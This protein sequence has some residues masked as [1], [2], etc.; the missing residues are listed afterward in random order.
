MPTWPASLDQTVLANLTR[1]RQSAKLRSSVDVGPAKQRK[2]YT[3]AVKQFQASM[4]MTGTQLAT[5]D[6]FYE[7][8]IGQGALS[9]DWINPVTDVTASLRFHDEPQ[10]TLRRPDSDPNERLYMVTLPLEILP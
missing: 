4:L 5:F 10:V 6:A 7:N 1:Q 2:R 9:F 3:A 8:D